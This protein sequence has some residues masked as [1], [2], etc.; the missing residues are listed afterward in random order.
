MSNLQNIAQRAIDRAKTNGASAADAMIREDDT[1]SVTVRMGEVE[2]LKEAISRSLMLR[3]FIGKRTATSH[4]SD[5]S[6]AVLDLLVDETVEM[7]RLTSED[8]SGGLPEEAI[9][10]SGFPDLDLLDTSWETMTPDERISLALRTEAAALS[11]DKAITNSEGASFEYARSRIALANTQGFNGSYEGTGAGLYCVP[12]AQSKAGMQRDH[13]MSAAR[14][15]NQLAT[16]EE[17][18]KRAAERA[19]RRLGARKI[20][21][22]RVPVIFDPLSAR[23]L[24]NHIFEAVSGSAIYRRSSFLVDQIGQPV[25]SPNV[26]VV[27]DALMPAGLGS[28]PFDDEG[29]PTQTTAIIENGVLKNYLHSAYT[30]RKLGSKPT[31]SGT[32][33]ASGAVTI[34]P[35]NFYLKAGSHKP[36]EILSSVTKGLYVVELI[37]FGVNTVSG[38]YSRG[39]VGL[40]IENGKLTHP[41]QEVTIAGNLREMLKNIEMIG[42]DV[43][44][45]GSIAAPTLK[46]GNM[47]I[48]GA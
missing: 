20:P 23:S 39:A 48:S 46:I 29:V 38:D 3:V 41:V 45:I 9:Q 25:A 19:L 26:T 8:K 6:P 11:A 7:A 28:S 31:G 40:W 35:T 32:R 18:G 36:D 21:T 5:L 47:V 37:G 10:R 30:A 24:L 27:D 17:I 16:P 43:T 34:G 2:T 22:C 44:F 33:A 12:I 15:R 4:T 14:H 13:W 1:F 42:D